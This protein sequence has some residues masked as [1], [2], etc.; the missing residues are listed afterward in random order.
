MSLSLSVYVQLC[1]TV[2]VGR[3]LVCVTT[4]ATVQRATLDSGVLKKVNVATNSVLMC[5]KS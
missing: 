1:V 3:E 5:F 4:H 2:D